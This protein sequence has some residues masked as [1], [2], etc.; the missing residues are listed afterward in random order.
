[1]SGRDDAGFSLSEVL[2]SMA[3]MSIAMAITSTGIYQMYQTTG[4]AEAAADAQTSL[5]LAFDRL[6]REVRYAARVSEQY[7]YN[8]SWAIDYVYA[9]ESG[10][11]RC[12][13]LSLPQA[14]GTL[15]RKE[16]GQSTILTGAVTGSAVANGIANARDP[17]ASGNPVNP[18]QQL[19]AGSDSSQ[20]DRLGLDV[21]ATVGSGEKSS[22]RVYNLQFT[23]QNT[24]SRTSNAL[25][26]TK[27]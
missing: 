16:W 9:D 12:V 25:S 5:Q 23:A 18:F 17:D 27:A 1:M 15:T 22:T 10:A 3:I 8:S 26:C 14:G 11:Y 21:Q 20:L 13:Q 2:V 6:D 4:D 7:V 24:V 19:A